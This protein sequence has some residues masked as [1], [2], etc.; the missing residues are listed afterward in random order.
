MNR[1]EQLPALMTMMETFCEETAAQ[2]AK[3]A[4]S[5]KVVLSGLAVHRAQENLALNSQSALYFSVKSE[6]LGGYIIFG[7]GQDLLFNMTDVA[8]GGSGQSRPAFDRRPTSIETRIAAIFATAMADSLV[9]AFSKI[10]IQMDCGVEAPSYVPQTMSVIKDNASVIAASVSIGFGPIVALA[11]VLIPQSLLAP[12]KDR[13][14]KAAVDTPPPRPASVDTVWSQQIHHELSR[15]TVRVTTILE[16]RSMTLDEI[17]NLKV[18]Q[19]VEL[20]ATASSLVRME[21]DDVPLF[22]CDLGRHG[23][24]LALRV[25]DPID[26][27]QEF[28]DGLVKS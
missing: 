14:A 1:L 6:S 24:A 17:V 2:F 18:G 22:W 28:F 15:T 16:E 10:D 25:Q 26:R 20:S 4:G 3:V 9:A 27:D 21:S 7:F 5:P 23:T 12:Y 13:L 8:L 11:T 19:I